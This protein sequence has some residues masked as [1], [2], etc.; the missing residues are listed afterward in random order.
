VGSAALTGVAGAQRHHTKIGAVLS[1][2]LGDVCNQRPPRC[3]LPTHRAFEGAAAHL[4]G[5]ARGDSNLLIYFFVF[6]SGLLLDVLGVLVDAD[7]H[8]L[9][10]D[11]G[12]LVLGYVDLFA[13]LG[14]EDELA[15]VGLQHVGH[16]E[17]HAVVFQRRRRLLRKDLCIGF[18]LVGPL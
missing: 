12:V 11:V 6:L 14:E 17:R 8:E 4:R 1:I 7:L 10:L 16:N 9:P 3:V 5:P 2:A 15:L 18:Q 13:R